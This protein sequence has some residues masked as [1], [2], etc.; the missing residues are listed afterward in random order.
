MEATG[1]AMQGNHK[2]PAWIVNGI[3]NPHL[4]RFLAGLWLC[5]A[6]VAGKGRRFYGL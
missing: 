4:K 2:I 1:V 3:N 6:I 5:Q